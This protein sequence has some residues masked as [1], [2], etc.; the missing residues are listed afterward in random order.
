MKMFIKKLTETATLPTQG[1]TQAAGYDIYADL[2]NGPVTIL[3]G[4]IQKI[5]TG[6]SAAPGDTDVALCLFPRSGL[7]TKKGVTL[8][9]SVGLVDSD[10]RGEIIVPLVNFGSQPVTIMN[11]DRIAQLVVLPIIKAEFEEVAELPETER[12]ES[13]FGSTGV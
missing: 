6:I 9:N 7:A 3:P 8:I 5:S 10:Y 4:D 13:G 1:S 2:P 12:G 11:D